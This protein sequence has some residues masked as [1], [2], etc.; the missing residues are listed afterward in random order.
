MV[1]ASSRNVTPSRCPHGEPVAHDP[2]VVCSVCTVAMETEHVR[3]I[4]EQISKSQ[5]LKEAAL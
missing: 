5:S 3:F 2:I 1:L 4:L